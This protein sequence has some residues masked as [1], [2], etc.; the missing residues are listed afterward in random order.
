[1]RLMAFLKW[2]GC[3]GVLCALLGFATLGCGD[4]EEDTGGGG[5]TWTCFDR[6][7]DGQCDCYAVPPGE[8][9]EDVS[10]GAMEVS[11]CP[12]YERCIEYY[13]TFFEWDG[14]SCGPSDMMPLDAMDIQTVSACPPS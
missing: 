14:C 2:F 7:A 5:A 9:Y 10:E 1:M 11:S 3:R 13:D 4:D 12:S 6:A 8:Q